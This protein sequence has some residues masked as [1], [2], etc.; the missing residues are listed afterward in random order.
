M[1]GDY[2]EEEILTVIYATRLLRKKKKKTEKNSGLME[3][4]IYL[5]FFSV[6]F[7]F[8]NSLVAYSLPHSGF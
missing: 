4:F 6:F 8:C 1:F 7:L 2:I 5:F 3:L